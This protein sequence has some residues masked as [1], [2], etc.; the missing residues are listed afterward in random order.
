MNTLRLSPRLRRLPANRFRFT[1]LLLV[2]ARR[3]PAKRATLL[4]GT[5]STSAM[6]NFASMAAGVRGIR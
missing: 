6:W 4:M 5:S 1:P 3:A 2:A